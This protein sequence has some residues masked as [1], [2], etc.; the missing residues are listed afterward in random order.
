MATPRPGAVADRRDTN[1]VL[2]IFILL[3][4]HG[5]GWSRSS[6]SATLTRRTGAIVITR[7]ARAEAR[8]TARRNLD[9]NASVLN[10]TPIASLTLMTD[11]VTP[12]SGP[13]LRTS[14][15]AAQ[16]RPANDDPQTDHSGASAFSGVLNGNVLPD[17]PTGTSKFSTS[18][19][20][21]CRRSCGQQHRAAESARHATYRRRRKYCKQRLPQWPRMARSA[22]GGAG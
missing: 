15:R 17:S 10:L 1:N 21:V 18:A 22:F 16:L 9:G 2:N 13:G 5:A 11:A 6:R 3:D 19:R 12:A 4:D 7:R 14:C 20:G 8:S